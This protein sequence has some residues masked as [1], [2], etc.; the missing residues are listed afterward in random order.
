MSE[1]NETDPQTEPVET[2]VDFVAE[3]SAE[4]AEGPTGDPVADLHIKLADAEKRALMAAADLENFRRRNRKD[5][6]ERVRYAASGLITDLLE[7]VDNLHRA[8]TA[9]NTDPNGDALRDGV[10]LVTQQITDVLT[11]HGCKPIEA[12]GQ[13]FDPNRHQALQM[14]PSD[15]FDANTIMM[16]V[17]TGFQLHDRVLRPSQVFVSTGPNPDA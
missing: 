11:K 16:D 8:V 5:N 17:R 4:T 6:E 1:N 7:S 10:E 15:Q 3:A 2:P 13:P 12:T 14:Q 9:Y